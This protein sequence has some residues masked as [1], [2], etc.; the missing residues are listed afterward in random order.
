MELWHTE[1][2]SQVGSTVGQPLFTNRLT[3]GKKTDYAR[4][5]IEVK[6]DC[7]FVDSVPVILDKKRSINLDT[8]YNWMPTRCS[9]CQVSGLSDAK[10][11]KDGKK[12]KDNLK[13]WMQKE[14]SR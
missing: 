7:T 8:E 13:V 5:C 10:C 12:H 6:V 9:H 11:P 1:G 4:M 14:G 3:V 2:F